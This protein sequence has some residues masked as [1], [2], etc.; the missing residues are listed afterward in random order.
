MREYCIG[1]EESAIERENRVCIWNNLYREKEQMYLELFDELLAMGNETAKEKIM[2]IIAEGDFCEIYSGRTNIAYLILIMDIYQREID[3][4]ETRT[5]LDMGSSLKTL[6]Q[7]FNQI[8]FFIWRLEYAVEDE[9]NRELIAMWLKENKP[10]P[11]MLEYII[12]VTSANVFCDIY[13]L[14]ELCFQ[15]RQY[16][17]SYYLFSQLN[18]ETPGNE[19]VCVR[20]AELYIIASRKDD[21]KEIIRTIQNPGDKVR[22]VREKYGL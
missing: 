12:N 22:T 15:Y 10:S 18:A 1:T 13:K 20:L 5:I 2:D 11:Y 9:G 16:R 6:I 21:A 17:I 7:I 19:D 3:N 14:A 8:K 4:G